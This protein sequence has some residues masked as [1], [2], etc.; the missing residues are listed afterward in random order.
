[1]PRRILE[2]PWISKV[3][4][5]PQLTLEKNVPFL[6]FLEAPPTLLCAVYKLEWFPFFQST[7]RLLP[8][9]NVNCIDAKG[10]LFYESRPCGLGYTWRENKI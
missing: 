10:L 4:S 5:N 9:A 7:K 2:F 8:N 6:G 3:P 1:M